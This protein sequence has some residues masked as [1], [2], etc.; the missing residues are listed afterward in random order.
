MKEIVFGAK[1]ECTDGEAGEVVNILVDPEDR[2]VAHYVVKEKARPHAER[3]VPAYLVI[4]STP[5]LLKLNCTLAELAD[6]TAYRFNVAYQTNPPSRAGSDP[7][8]ASLVNRTYII[9]RTV[10]P[11]GEQAF[12]LHSK[13]E[14]KDG[15]VGRVDGVLTDE[16]TGEITHMLMR[17]G[18]A[19]GE[20]EVVIPVSLI[21]YSHEGTVYL[22]VD[23]D[24][25]LDQLTLSAAWGHGPSEDELEDLVDGE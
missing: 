16:E 7:Y 21:E 14:A 12:S 3:L 17:K 22:K 11:E 1:V 5:E 20:K 10:V 25:A 9:E 6:M 23:K 19:W 18:H 13:V 2:D 15:T 8:G 4:E 24:K